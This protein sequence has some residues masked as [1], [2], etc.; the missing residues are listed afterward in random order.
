MAKPK[1]DIEIARAAVLRPIEDIAESLSIPADAL[2]R[3]GP[4]KAKVDFD[5]L[6]SLQGRPGNHREFAT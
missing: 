2:F 4:H 5:F 6:K 1:S 3:Y